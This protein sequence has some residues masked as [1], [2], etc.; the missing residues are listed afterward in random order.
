MMRK[1]MITLVLL[2]TCL[3]GWAFDNDDYKAFAAQVRKEVWSRDM[4]DFKTRSVPAKY[5]NESAVILA[6]YE[7]VSVDQKRKFSIY[8]S[9]YSVKQ[10]NSGHLRRMLVK[11]QDKASLEKFST[12]DYST[13]R[14]QFNTG[15]GTDDVRNV[16]GVRV[17]KPDGSETEVSGDDYVSE[18]EGKRGQEKKAKL[19]V[20]NLQVGDLI[21][22]FS[23]YQSKVKEENVDPMRFVFEE[24]YPMLSYRVHCVI[25]RKFCTQYRTLNGAPDFTAST[26]EDGNV[27][28]DAEVKNVDRTQPDY[29]YNS[30]SMSPITLLYVTGKVDLGYLPKSTKDKGLHA[31]PDATVIQEDAWN[32][33]KSYN[34]GKWSFNKYLKNVIGQAKKLDSDEAKADHVYNFMVMSSLVNRQDYLDYRDLPCA[35]EDILKKCGVKMDHVLV[36]SWLKEPLGQLISYG[37]AAW[38]LRLKSGRYYLPLGYAVSASMI[39]SMY[40]GRAASV[41]T[42]EGNYAKG[43]FEQAVTPV[44]Q[45]QDNVERIA[46]QATVDGSH[47]NISRRSEYTGCCKEGLIDDYA[48]PDEIMRGWGKPY[49]YTRYVDFFTGKNAEDKAAEGMKNSEKRIADNF[50]DEVTQYHDRAPVAITGTKVEL[51]GENG[52]PLAYTVDYQMDGMVKTAG[53]NLVVSIGQLLGRHIHIEGR[54]RTRDC[55]IMRA[56]AKTYEVEVNLQLPAGYMVNAASLQRL[57]AHV[58]NATGSFE[59]AA[60]LDGGKLVLTVRKVYKHQLEPAANWPSLLE[61]LDAAYTFCSQQVVLRKK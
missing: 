47:L 39:P 13:Y 35:L 56:F 55:D 25:D 43:P 26:D 19:A 51:V 29:G 9:G 10:V 33:W 14:R 52:G 50:R 61:V 58:D 54:E 36:T 45:A 57:G 41:Y 4:P 3:T 38:A 48:T 44:S 1:A 23:Y 42:G 59:A 46:V 6:S 8:S 15:F 12:F 5:K 34:K 37:N 22:V 18:T 28:L 40:Q 11:I 30:I 7:E 53:Q 60:R 31:N 49:G 16:L 27:V 2:A 17:I 21:D 20:P 32:W 24:D